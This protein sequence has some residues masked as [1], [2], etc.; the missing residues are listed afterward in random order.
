MTEVI[1][2]E[3][4]NTNFLENKED[5]LTS[6]KYRI[7]EV[8]SE[9]QTN[10][11]YELLK[12]SSKSSG[13]LSSRFC[14]F[15]QEITIQFL[16]PVKIK[17]INIISHENKI[18]SHVDVYNYYPF[19]NNQSNNNK[20]N[21]NSKIQY[22]NIGFITFDPNNR[23]NYQAKEFKKIFLDSINS[24]YLK[25]SFQK[26]HMNK[27]NVFN[28]VGLYTI[29]FFGS[30]IE[31]PSSE[32]YNIL[33]RSISQK[34]SNNEL[35]EN[36][37][38]DISSEKLKL[39][40]DKLADALKIE[41]YDEAS[42]LKVIIDKIKLIGKRIAEL[43]NQKKLYVE[44]E[45]FSNA[46]IMKIEVDK[47]KSIM[48]NIEKPIP[49]LKI[50]NNFDIKKETA[51]LNNSNVSENAIKHDNNDNNEQLSILDDNMDNIENS[52]N[53]KRNQQSFGDINVNQSMSIGESKE[54]FDATFKNHTVMFKELEENTPE[55]YDEIVIP[56]LRNKNKQKEQ[57][58]EDI[59]KADLEELDK[60]TFQQYEPM[61]KYITEEEL[62]KLFSKQII[63]REEGITAFT[64]KL[65]QIFADKTSTG[66]NINLA[67]R[68]L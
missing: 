45:D 49:N 20:S 37:L 24:S 31:N 53:T 15:P 13:W 16:S 34:Q 33:E 68:L 36:E 18:S 63:Y 60:P 54:V 62:R 51:Y 47:L 67:M 42:K 8:T 19:S 1:T 25:L 55:V 12:P 46:K 26:N 52:N 29:E 61:L 6:L 39:Y 41:D 65:N 57:D 28:Q 21:L 38:D 30:Y 48:K 11:I 35:I 64:S 59:I 2:Q 43:E 50:I 40:K 17:Q 22:N 44:N 10:S 5:P 23:T 58:E 27:Y 4:N 56:A 7:I 9:H 14:Y 32:D 3:L 66:A